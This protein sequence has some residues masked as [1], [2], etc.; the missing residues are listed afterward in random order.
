[1]KEWSAYRNTLSPLPSLALAPSLTLPDLLRSITVCQPAAFYDRFAIALK[2]G[3][4][5]LILAFF[6]IERE[7]RGVGCIH[8]GGVQAQLKLP[9]ILRSK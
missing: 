7:W 8:F 9:A 4:L 5:A 6:A 3:D 1:M 2:G